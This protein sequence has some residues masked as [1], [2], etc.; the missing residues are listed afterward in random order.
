MIHLKDDPKSL[1]EQA[2]KLG[3]A[4]FGPVM[5]RFCVWLAEQANSCQAGRL[6]FLSREGYF[7]RKLFQKARELGLARSSREVDPRY[8]L[9]SRRAAFGAG[10]KTRKSLHDMLMGGRFEGR[11]YDLLEGRIGYAK[12]FAEAQGI[13]NETVVLPDA[14]DKVL[15]VLASK[16]PA[17][18]EHADSERKTLERHLEQEGFAGADKAFVVDLGY[19]ASIQRSLQ[20]IT[21][22]RMMGFY[23]ATT[24]QAESS[25]NSDNEVRAC[26]AS[27]CSVSK[28]PPV[29]RYSLALESWL[30]SPDGQVLYFEE[31]DGKV[32]P[33]FA[34]PGRMQK[35]F[36]L[37]ES[38]AQGVEQ[39]FEDVA[40]LAPFQE[41]WKDSL[42]ASAEDVMAVALESHEFAPILETLSVEDP[43]CGH[44]EISVA[45][46]IEELSS[47]FRLSDVVLSES[48]GG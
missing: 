9:I 45:E 35:D 2:E 1:T 42:A 7:L 16:L 33:R 28:A 20:S 36:A 34:P 22:Q 43:F 41:N 24:K 8:L 25:V 5:L 18:N 19:S 47:T 27:G 39:Y 32:V 14:T 3:Y 46:K 13:P 38:V 11:L 40:F 30:T 29:Y 31:K 23:F 4:A 26:F 6:Y 10:H 44:G 37:A 21:G 17:L 15:D 48:E 12:A